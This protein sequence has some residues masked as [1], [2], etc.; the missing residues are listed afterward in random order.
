[1]ALRDQRRIDKVPKVASVSTRVTRPFWQMK[2]SRRK[3]WVSGAFVTLLAAVVLVVLDRPEDPL[4]E[5]KPLSEHLEAFREHGLAAANTGPPRIDLECSN[6]RAYEAIRAVGTQALPMLTEMLGSTDRMYRWF[7][8]FS[9]RQ[10]WIRKY[11]KLRPPEAWKRQ[12]HALAAFIE[13]GPK[14]APAIPRILPLLRDPE[15]ATVAI[16]AL[17]AIQPEREADILSLTNVLRISRDGSGGATPDL[18]HGNALVALSTFGRRAAGAK[19]VLLDCLR[20]GSPRA[21]GAAA[22]ALA[23]IGVPA[24]EVVPQILGHLPSVETPVGLPRTGPMPGPGGFAAMHAQEEAERV[25]LMNLSALER[26]GP[27]AAA[28]VPA[29]THLAS[30]P[31]PEIGRAVRAALAKIKAGTNAVER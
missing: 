10:P 19:P 1:M 20:T 21:Q 17:L 9:A 13:L 27:A 4:F 25:A 29:L 12:V 28:A 11:V 30:H 22:I 5:G 2:I 18:Q 26:F 8:E 3:L 31:D 16:V 6:P 24:V 7:E 14:A 15:C 23:E